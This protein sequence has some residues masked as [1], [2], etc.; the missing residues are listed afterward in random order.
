[1]SKSTPLARPIRPIRQVALAP[2]IPLLLALVAWLGLPVVAAGEVLA[3]AAVE[4][5]TARP[6]T[7]RAPERGLFGPELV[8]P[9]VRLNDRLGLDSFPEDS[10][11]W[12]ERLV[13]A[14]EHRAGGRVGTSAA[15]E[16][17]PGRELLWRLAADLKA[18]LAD[19]ALAGDSNGAAEPP[20]R[21]R[22]KRLQR[23][24][25][26]VRLLHDKLDLL[27]REQGQENTLQ[28]FAV[29]ANDAC[30]SAAVIGLGT[31]SGSTVEATI[32]GSSSC[33]ASNNRPDVWYRYTAAADGL[34]T[35]TVSGTLLD[36]ALSLH[37]GC[38]GDPGALELVCSDDSGGTLQPEVTWDLA[39]GEEVWVRVSGYGGS[40][41]AF[42]LTVGPARGISGTVTR[43]DT[44]APVAGAGVEIYDQYGSYLTGVATSADGTYAVGGLA[45]GDYYVQAL[46][47]GL[48][49]ELY[50]D[51][52]CPFWLVC[53]P[54]YSGDPVHVG[55]SGLTT[56]IDFALAQAG[57]LSGTVTEVATGQGVP[58][59]VRL[60]SVTG[61]HLETYVAAA[62]GTYQ[63]DSLP[64][65]TYF[66]VAEQ[67]GYLTEVYDEIPCPGSC[68]P[69]TGTG[70]AVVGGTT[71]TGIDFTLDRLGTISGT[72]T[73]AGTGSPLS[74][75]GVTVYDD[76]GSPGFPIFTLSDGSYESAG[77]ASG[78]YFVRTDTSDH[79]DELYDGIACE[80]SCD[81]TTGTP[82]GVVV[83]TQTAGIDFALSPLGRIAGTVLEAGTATPVSGELVM[84]Y[85]S[86]GTPSSSAATASD[87][88][89][90]VRGLVPGTYRVK[91]ATETHQNELWDDVVCDP[92]CDVSTGDPV[93]VSSG[94]TTSGIDFALARRGKI[95]GTVTESVG[96]LPVASAAVNFHASD[97]AWI[98][99]VYTASDGTYESPSLPDGSYHVV[100]APSSATYVGQ[101]YD[102]LP[103]TDSCTVT[104][105]APVAVV[106]ETTTSGIDFVLDRYGVIRGTVTAADTGNGL[107]GGVAVLDQMGTGVRSDYAGAG[108]VFMVGSI[109]PGTYYVRISLD[110]PGGASQYQDEVFD[111]VGCEPTCD[112]TL[113]TPISVALNSIVEG[114]DL[115]LAPCPAD[116][117][118]DLV[119]TL[120]SAT[121][122]EGACERLTAGG[123]TIVATG[124]DVTF[125]AGR[126]IVLTDGFVVGSGASFRAVI[127]PAWASN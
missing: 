12:A 101:I 44:G 27:E 60:F 100:A 81:A 114:V 93:A 53:Y 113:G 22:A 20:G 66:L 74:G 85:D 75:Q 104:V 109:P 89:Y 13:A 87:G 32:D 49:S 112:L 40:A 52:S 45:E 115:V 82:V 55:A 43:Q 8:G 107:Q 92:S 26:A 62:D 2:S 121:R 19:Q 78:T 110:E 83:A 103:C 80:P 95:T 108:G 94:S 117:N 124:A 77:L 14:I 38:P 98:G 68:D 6:D 46:K 18:L 119:N 15:V 7:P 25:E 111:G 116:T 71:V 36:T 3:A 34:M 33:D 28:A 63:I 72:V 79:L 47:T 65:G 21:T 4:P 11:R 102:G 24:R 70:I 69:T 31:V 123:N 29:P 97:G 106:H 41:G 120:L 9:L 54:S 59:F 16:A 50:N 35:F 73:D 23:I 96:G 90:E 17:V 84:A 118:V 122:V 5:T 57:G 48:I 42:D 58:A 51:V 125:K 56:G 76:L 64:S 99:S 39:A 88:S 105:G 86:A 126:K 91:T 61:A 1:V 67:S 37:T 10:P 30:A 127:E